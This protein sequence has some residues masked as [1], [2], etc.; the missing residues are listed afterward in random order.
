VVCDCGVERPELALRGP[1]TCPRH[2]VSNITAPGCCL[3]GAAGVVPVRP[4]QSPGPP[5][6]GFSCAFF[7]V[8]QIERLIQTARRIEVR[9]HELVDRRAH[10]HGGK[11]AGHARSLSPSSAPR[12]SVLT[13]ATP[14][15][16]WDEP[17]SI[18]VR[19]DHSPI[20]GMAQRDYGEPL[21]VGRIL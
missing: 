17:G 9:P 19:S 4:V 15:H 7:L 3:A 6:D 20:S 12:T 18:T 14:V 5:P 1:G 13:A 2:E 16:T 10:C 11:L 21:I 8:R